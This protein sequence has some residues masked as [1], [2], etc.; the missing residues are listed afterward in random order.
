MP[1]KKRGVSRDAIKYWAMAA[2]FCNHFAHVLLTPSSPW[3]E[4]LVDVGYF[5]AVTM[6]YFLT[7]GYRYTRSRR[8]YALRLLVFGLVSQLPYTLALG[9]LQLNMM[10]TLLLC[11]GILWVLDTQPPGLFQAVTVAALVLASLYTDWALL[12]PVFT[13]LFAQSGRDTEK[14]AA[15]FGAA[16]LLF[17]GVNLLSYLGGPYT[18]PQALLH[19]GGTG[20][21]IL[22]SGAVI[23]FC[24]NGQRAK[25]GRAF[26]KWFFYLFYPAHLLALWLVKM[27]LAQ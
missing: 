25:R 18:L 3:F 10:F 1:E 12:A 6:C 27:A 20:L 17:F 23:L 2:M 4:P 21:G 15:S 8:R 22:A 13:I 26:S 7:E 24:Y 5:T 9:V 14:L 11:F 16:A 19:A